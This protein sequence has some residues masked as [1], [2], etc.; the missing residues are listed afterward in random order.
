VKVFGDAA[1]PLA[2]RDL[3]V[4]NPGSL[5]I[6]NELK[7]DVVINTAAYVRVDDAEVELEEAFRVNAIGALN[8][9]KVCDEVKAINVYISTDYVFDGTKKEP[10]TEDD[11]PNPINVYGL[12]KYTGELFSRNYCKNYYVI[13]V[14]SLYGRAGSSG[15]G[16]NFVEFMIQKAR[17]GEE[18]RVVDDQFMSPTTTKD[19]AEMLKL[20]LAKKPAFGVYHMVNEGWCS[21][22]EFTEEIFKILGRGVHVT[23]IAS[24]ELKRLARRPRF[25][26][27]ENTQ[28]EKLGI[29]MRTWREALRDYLHER[30]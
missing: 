2:H 18:M 1:I 28:L 29:R 6:L 19:V 13:R 11:A 4:T 23:P 16:G 26:A 25:S 9:A 27:L 7:P 8:V 14:S 17:N 22:Y 24:S 20:F 5:K 15:K 30:L 3:D 21:W 12:S 10:Y